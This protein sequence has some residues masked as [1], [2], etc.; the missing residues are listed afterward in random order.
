M[1][2]PDVDP[3]MLLKI[4]KTSI[5]NVVV[6]EWCNV[7]VIGTKGYDYICKYWKGDKNV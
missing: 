6:G 4:D 7:E 5:N 1:D 3:K 2:A